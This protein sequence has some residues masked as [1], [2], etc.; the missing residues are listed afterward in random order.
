[1]SGAWTEAEPM[2]GERGFRFRIGGHAS[3]SFR[4]GRAPPRKWH[5]RPRARCRD[6]G[7]PPFEIMAM[8]WK[9]G[10][11]LTAPTRRIGSE[12]EKQRAAP[13][14]QPAGWRHAAVTC[15]RY[16]GAAGVNAL[17]ISLP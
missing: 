13:H 9:I 4:P 7:R 1:R 17:R 11:G 15:T 8:A 16:L 10:R 12:A 2:Q 14:P 6:C 3:L 5:D